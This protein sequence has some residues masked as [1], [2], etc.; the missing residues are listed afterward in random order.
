M[1]SYSDYVKLKSAFEIFIKIGF[2]YMY[3][4]NFLYQSSLFRY[5]ASKK[6]S[7]DICL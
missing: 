7:E 4:E 1:G 6:F 5:Y 3:G 2:E